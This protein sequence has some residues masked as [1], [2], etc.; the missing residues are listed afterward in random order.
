MLGRA[1]RGDDLPNPSRS[2]AMTDLAEIF[3]SAAGKM[4]HFYGA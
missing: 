2:Y 3:A 1:A 4:P